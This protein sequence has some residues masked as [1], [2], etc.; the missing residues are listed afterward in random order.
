MPV[1]ERGKSGRNHLFKIPWA[2]NWQLGMNCCQKW[3]K[4]LPGT[5]ETVLTGYALDNEYPG[6]SFEQWMKDAKALAGDM[7]YS[8]S[9]FYNALQY[10]IA[11]NLIRWSKRRF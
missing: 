2:L 11:N 7:G 9:A 6:F 8:E 5:L 3:D 4:P 1:L 10:L